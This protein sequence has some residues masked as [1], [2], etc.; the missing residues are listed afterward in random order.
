[1]FK[2]NITNLYKS[3]LSGRFTSP[4]PLR[5]PSTTVAGTPLAYYFLRTAPPPKLL[6]FAL[7]PLKY[8]ILGSQKAAQNPHVCSKKTPEILVVCSRCLKILL[9]SLFRFFGRAREERSIFKRSKNE[10]VTIS[11]DRVQFHLPKTTK[12]E[13]PKTRFLPKKYR[14]SKRL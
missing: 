1:M 2:K 6:M 14:F 5:Q 4:L 10:N 3:L 13:P 7:R 11:L 9:F 12:R 8:L